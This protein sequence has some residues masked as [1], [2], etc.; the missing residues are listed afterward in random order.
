[1]VVDFD[2][3]MIRSRDALDQIAKGNPD[4]YKA[5][6]SRRDDITL[7]NPFGGFGRGIE[8][9]YEQLERAAS[10]YCDGERLPSRR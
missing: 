10:H 7:G 3:V 4:G 9:V 2:E 1:M 8:A 5:L 6:Y